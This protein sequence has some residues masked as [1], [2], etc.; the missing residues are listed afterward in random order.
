MPEDY[1]AEEEYDL[2]AYTLDFDKENKLKSIT[3]EN[4]AVIRENVEN[5][6]LPTIYNHLKEKSSE[7]KT[8]KHVINLFE[9]KF[10]GKEIDDMLLEGINESTETP[11]EY[12]KE[13]KDQAR[14]QMYTRKERKALLNVLTTFTPKELHETNEI[15][16]FD[17]KETIKTLRDNWDQTMDHAVSVAQE[18]REKTQE[19]STKSIIQDEYQDIVDQ[20]DKKPEEFKELE[21]LPKEESDRAILSGLLK[22]TISKLEEMQEID[23]DKDYLKP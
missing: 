15:G 20:V 19:K 21:D 3:K 1:D 13:I 7:E 2:D 8:K 16:R 18:R 22:N 4:R 11:E 23:E 6:S 5:T 9:N 17:L 12:V 10:H 14:P